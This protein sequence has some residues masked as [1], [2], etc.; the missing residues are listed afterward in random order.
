MTL[1]LDRE[2]D[3]PGSR[4]SHGAA[5]GPPLRASCDEPDHAHRWA[6]VYQP[7]QLIGTPDSA[8]PHTDVGPRL[9]QRLA[10]GLLAASGLALT[11][12]SKK[13]LGAGDDMHTER[14]ALVQLDTWIADQE[15]VPTGTIEIIWFIEKP[16][17]QDGCV[18]VLKRF[19]DA[20]NARGVK[21]GSDVQ[22]SSPLVDKWFKKT[23][24]KALERFPA[25]GS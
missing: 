17:C 23:P 13:K 10:I 9:L 25:L 8:V 20:W 3:C 12:G 24:G 15:L 2:V 18:P 7:T 5:P 16:M 14:F 22:S 19:T 1:P 11:K 21:V 6:P 4:A